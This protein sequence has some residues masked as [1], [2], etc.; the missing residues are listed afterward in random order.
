[1]KGPGV[2]FI[3]MAKAK[4]PPTTTGFERRLHAA[5]NAA[6]TKPLTLP[7][8]A[9]RPS[10]AE[11]KAV[12]AMPKSP[13]VQHRYRT[14]AIVATMFAMPHTSIEGSPRSARGRQ[15]TATGGGASNGTVQ[16]GGTIT[17]LLSPGLKA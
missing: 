14:V 16:Y 9:S 13:F 1:R 2:S 5:T 11:R 3:A 4:V 12:A 8:S 6:S 17:T 7:D 15:I 10:G